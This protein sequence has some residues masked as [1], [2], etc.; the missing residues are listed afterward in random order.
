MPESHQINIALLVGVIYFNERSDD[1]FTSHPQEDKVPFS[2]FY[3]EA[4]SCFEAGVIIL[5]TYLKERFGIYFK[6]KSP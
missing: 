1:S 5:Y 6:A 4:N 3:Y 2:L